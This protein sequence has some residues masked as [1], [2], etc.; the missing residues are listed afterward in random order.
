MWNGLLQAW[1]SRNDD[2]HGHD[3]TTKTSR[4]RTSLKQRIGRLYDMPPQ[5]EKEDQRFFKNTIEEWETK[6]N[7]EISDW[8]TVAEPLT[9]EGITRAQQRAHNQS[10]ITSYF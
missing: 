1:E 5:L 2:Q 8:L 9:N 7:K 10:L 6:T 3:E 4:E